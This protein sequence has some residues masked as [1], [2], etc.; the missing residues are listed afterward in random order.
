MFKTNETNVG[1]DCFSYVSL[2][3]GHVFQCLQKANSFLWNYS[4]VFVPCYDYLLTHSIAIILSFF[5]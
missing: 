5:F 2:C 3:P 4:K 1:T